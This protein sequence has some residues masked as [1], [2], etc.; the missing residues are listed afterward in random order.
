MADFLL[1]FLIIGYCIFVIVHRHK[2][3]KKEA[4][5]GNVRGLVL[6]AAADALS[7]KNLKTKRFQVVKSKEENSGFWLRR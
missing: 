6:A 2:K 1:L 5:L 4:S 3:A 7:E